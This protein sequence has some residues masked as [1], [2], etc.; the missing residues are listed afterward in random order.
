MAFIN[1]NVNFNGKKNNQVNCDRLGDIDFS[2]WRH[3]DSQPAPPAPEPTT[4]TGDDDE[5]EKP[6]PEPVNPP[7]DG[8]QINHAEV[9]CQ[10]TDRRLKLIK[11]GGKNNPWNDD[12]LDSLIDWMKP[13]NGVSFKIYFEHHLVVQ[14]VIESLVPASRKTNSHHEPTTRISSPRFIC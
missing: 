10:L 6:K 1:A 2:A 5:P 11:C 8:G 14:M 3:S 4:P 7:G 13:K 9:A 12:H